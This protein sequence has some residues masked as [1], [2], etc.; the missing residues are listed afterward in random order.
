MLRSVLQFY[1][2]VE[3]RYAKCHIFTVILFVIMSWGLYSKTF[4]SCDCSRIIKSLSVCHCYSLLAKSNISGQ[5]LQPTISVKCHKGL[6]SDRLQ[7][8]TWLEVENTLAYSLTAT[9]MVVKSFIEQESISQ[10]FLGVNLLT[11]F[12]KLELFIPMEQI[13]LMFIKWYSL[14]KV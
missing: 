10:N 4:Y 12:C 7:Y 9:I 6:H 2:Y 8:Q 13:L 1:C 11:L 3:C 14:Q 5:C